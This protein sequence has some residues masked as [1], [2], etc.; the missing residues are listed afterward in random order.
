MHFWAVLGPSYC[1]PGGWG[2]PT[3]SCLSHGMHSE[4]A[5]VSDHAVAPLHCVAS[6]EAG[7]FSDSL[8]CILHSPSG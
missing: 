7:L 3:A 6:R 2:T 4:N 8:Q 1:S 5:A